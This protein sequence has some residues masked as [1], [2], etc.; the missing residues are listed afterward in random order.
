MYLCD[1]NSTTGIPSSSVDATSLV[2]GAE[3]LV[4]VLRDGAVSREQLREV[5]GD[6]LEPDPGSEP[7]DS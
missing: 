4:R 6:L 2:G 1:A 5:L 7:D 3:P